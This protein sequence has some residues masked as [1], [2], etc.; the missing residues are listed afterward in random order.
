MSSPTESNDLQRS[1]SFPKIVQQ[2]QPTARVNELEGVISD[3]GRNK[4]TARAQKIRFNT[5]EDMVWQASPSLL[6]LIPRLIKYAILMTAAIVLCSYIEVWEGQVESRV[7]AEQA[8]LAKAAARLQQPA[9]PKRIGSH[10][11][12][13]TKPASVV[14]PA[15]PAPDPGSSQVDPALERL[16][17]ILLWFQYGV[18]GVLLIR[19]GGYF[20]SL[21]CTRYQASSQRLVVEW[22]V[23]RTY[24]VPYELHHIGN[25]VIIKP[26]LLRPFGLA[27]VRIGQ[28]VVAGEPRIGH[29][30][31]FELRGIRNA[32]LVRDLLRTGG[33]LEAQRT[34]KIRWR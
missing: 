29:R 22:G 33:Q 27:H 10:S 17:Q 4:I 30:P 21:R 20:L 12:R 8:S 3:I 31:Y 11:V 32:D 1:S 15:T 2:P 6:L 23:R 5:D 24:N 18:A 34:D 28:P 25:A 14:A 26:L 19:L 7:K 9:P 13:T 16:N